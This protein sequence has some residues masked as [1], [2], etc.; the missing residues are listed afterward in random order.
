MEELTD[1]VIEWSLSQPLI[2]PN[3]LGILAVSRDSGKTICRAPLA[4]EK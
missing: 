1:R 2:L 3:Q 4:D